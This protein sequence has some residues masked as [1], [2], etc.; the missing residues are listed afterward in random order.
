M[1]M[2]QLYSYSQQEET[3]YL[4]L[5][6]EEYVVYVVPNCLEKSSDLQ[7]SLL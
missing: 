4:S 5:A 7:T 1:C 6:M 3:L 2:T